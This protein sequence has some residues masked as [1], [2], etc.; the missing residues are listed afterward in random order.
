MFRTYWKI[1]W[2]HVNKHKKFAII[3]VLGLAMGIC[4]S[5]IIFLVVHYEFSF[6]RSVPDRDR[7]FHLGYNIKVGEGADESWNSSR[8]MPGLPE[9]MRKELPGLEVVTGFFSGWEPKV[10]V[11]DKAAKSGYTEFSEPER[12]SWAET[13][14]ADPDYFSIFPYHWLAG[15]ASSLRM[16]FQV[17]LSESR[18]RRYFGH[19]P[20]AAI[21]G[22]ELVFDDSIH[23]NV[24]GIVADRTENTDFSTAEFVSFSTINN[25]GLRYHYATDEWKSPRGKPEIWAFVKLAK[26]VNPEQT[27]MQIDAIVKRNSPAGYSRKM[28]LQPLSDVHFNNA[29]SHDDI[30]KSSKPTLYGI[31]ALAGFILILAGINFVNLST[32]QSIRRAREVGVRKVLGSG[33]AGLTWQFL[34]ETLLVVLMSV[35]LAAFL[36]KPMLGIFHDFIPPGVS[37][38]LSPP[39]LLFLL[40]MTVMTTLL[41]GYY[42]ARVLSSYLPV[43]S[44]KGSAEYHDNAA[45]TLRRALIV[46]QFTISLIFIISTLVVG[47]QVRYMLKTD[48]GLKSDAIVTVGTDWRDSLAKVQVFEDKLSQIPGIGSVIREGGPPIGWGHGF[49]PFEFKGPHPVKTSEIQEGDESFIPFYHMRILA[50]RNL[51]HTN[52]LQELLVNETAAR[53]FGC[54]M[55]EDALGKFLYARIN[56]EERSFPIVGVV[57]D[58]HTESFRDPI[59]SLVIGHS[60]EQER[61]FGIRLATAGRGVGEVQKTLEAIR[62][63]YKNVYPDREFDYVFMDESIRNMYE[64]EQNLSMLVRSAMLVTIFISCMGLFGVSLF[65]AEKRTRE[66]GIRKVLGAGVGNIVLLLSRDFV[67]LVMLAI[68]IASPVAWWAMSHWLNGFPYRIPLSLPIFLWAGCCGIL[69]AMLTVSFHAI[70]AARANPVKS[71]KTEG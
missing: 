66:I 35:V 50:G 53:S 10:K 23:L 17:V 59:H 43:T 1:A 39:V 13:I 19:I 47:N 29:Y 7:I 41:A 31:M 71:L 49:F 28:L 54:S 67:L 57:A 55:P 51:H 56:G 34:T 27:S 14:I 6:D 40:G 58:Y 68:F 26:G 21:I 4:F 16:P 42:P 22:R 18:A 44:L 8:V 32:A 52:D 48:Y 3:N 64:A 9:A 5:L 69:I 63:A 62:S 38:T 37:F 60:P 11:P 2:R 25:S 33:R 70:H 45:W 65:S 20:L 61:Y 36:V 15:S 24:S 46:F 30:R 12:S